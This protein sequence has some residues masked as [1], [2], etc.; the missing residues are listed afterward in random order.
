MSRR[1]PGIEEAAD[2]LFLPKPLSA[3][4]FAE[5]FSAFSETRNAEQEL[6]L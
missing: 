4:W 3:C 5:H 2:I 1:N 6:S